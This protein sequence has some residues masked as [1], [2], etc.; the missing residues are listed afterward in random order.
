MLQF[1]IGKMNKADFSSVVSDISKL[2]MLSENELQSLAEEYPFSQSIQ[3]LL[4]KKL[5]MMESLNFEEQLNKTAAIVTSRSVLYDLLHDHLTETNIPEEKTEI[6][7]TV[8]RESEQAQIDELIQKETS[9]YTLDDTII[10]ETEVGQK[11]EE[12]LPTRDKQEFSGWLN[13][14]ESDKVESVDQSELI[15]KF[16]ANDPQISRPVLSDEPVTNLAKSS[17]ESLPD[18]MVTET[19][20]KIYLDQGNRSMAIEIY[21]R[22]KLKY[23]EKSPYFAGQIEFIKTK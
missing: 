7:E 21:E 4:T 15:D 14:F 13:F 19:L 5:K 18:E 22:L 1:Q 2:E 3:I 8:E 11:V 9:V 16:I 23:P 12:V 20:A 17:T 6:G 10:E